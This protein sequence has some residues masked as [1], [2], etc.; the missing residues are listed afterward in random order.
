MTEH[1]PL[2]QF[3]VVGTRPVRPDGID[4]VTGKAIYGP[5]HVA[6]GMIHGAIL[7]SPHPHARI[8][9]I[10]TSKALALPGVKAAVTG[11]DLPHLPGKSVSLGEGEADLANLSCNCLARD[12]ALYEGHAVAAVAATSASIAREALKLITV[13]YE[14]LP[15]VIDLEDAARDDAPI[16]HP[17]LRT[18]GAEEPS[19]KP[20]NIAFTFA[21]KQGDAAKAL[22]GAAAVASGRFAM[23]PVHQGYIEPHACVASWN[24]DGQGQVWCSSQGPFMVRAVTAGVLDIPV[25]DVR[26]TPLE[27]GG[28]FGGKTTIYLEP[29]AMLLSRK[30]GRPVR[31]AMSREDVFRASGPAPGLVV[32]IRIGADAEGNLVGIEADM[33]Y[34]AGAFPGGGTMLGPLVLSNMYRY[35]AVDIRT[36]DAVSNKPSVAAYRAPAAPQIT[37]AIESCIDDIAAQLGMDPIA[38]RLKNALRPGDT[39]AMGMECGEIGFVE[40]LDSANAQD[41]LKAPLGD[42][43]GRGI[44]AGYWINIGGASSASVSLAEDGSVAVV[45]GNP[46]I[47]GSRASMAIMASERLGVPYEKVRPIIGDTATIGYSVVTGGSRTTFAVGRAVVQACD[48]IIADMK[49]RA[50]NVW[51]VAE[52]DVEWRN[53][54]VHCTAKGNDN[55]PMTITEMAENANTTGGPIAAE[56]SINPHDSLP[57]YGVHICDV[58]VDPETGHVSIKRYTVVQDVG[59]AI[60]PDYVEG[61]MQGGAVQGIG[62]ALNEAYIYNSKGCLD[63]P[64]FLDYRMPVASDLPMIDTVIVEKPNPAHPYGVKGVGEVPIVPPLAAIGNA[65]KAATGKRIRELPMSPDRV[66][67]AINGGK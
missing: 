22:D 39:S 18:Q 23:P 24:A 16:L 48:T 28:G 63:N 14:V 10:D 34:D 59:R 15:H 53:G 5:D 4:K 67:A 43:E 21:L 1:N 56:V 9:S 42:N 35:P 44:A 13:D 17:D 40:C 38:F 65:V 64:G 47:G 8:R 7:R 33:L 54:A 41:H 55:A 2:S 49:K 19:D 31:L 20:T 45:T 6:P 26:V 37:F 60:H 3:R 11:Q 36:R 61:Q 29:V 30:A 66:F 58:A 62:W 51:Q 32:D 52:D 50:A 27:I 12:K 25:S 57:A 46:D